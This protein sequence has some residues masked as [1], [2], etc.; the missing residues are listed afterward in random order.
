MEG[1]LEVDHEQLVTDITTLWLSLV[2]RGRD[3]DTGDTGHRCAR[4]R[5]R[6]TITRGNDVDDD[7]RTPAHDVLTDAA[8]FDA[9]PH[10]VTVG[11][12]SV[13]DDVESLLTQ[14]EIEIGSWWAETDAAGDVVM[15]LAV[16]D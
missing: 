9:L 1:D 10:L 2:R 8:P 16:V 6:T 13:D 11:I 3:P 7:L 14:L 4:R 12:R 5:V 15:G